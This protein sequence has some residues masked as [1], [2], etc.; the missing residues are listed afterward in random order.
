MCIRDSLYGTLFAIHV[1]DA[2]AALA[3]SARWPAPKKRAG[4]L[5]PL[6]SYTDG[7]QIKP[8]FLVRWQTKAASMLLNAGQLGPVGGQHRSNQARLFGIRN[9]GLQYRVVDNAGIVMTVVVSFQA[10][11][12]E[13]LCNDKDFAL[14][15]LKRLFLGVADSQQQNAGSKFA[16][17]FKVNDEAAFNGWTKQH[18]FRRKFI[19]AIPRGL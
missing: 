15:R 6:K 10:H 7:T 13:V 5:F 1:C 17:V 3:R 16:H 8:V 9:H 19:K 2:R 4:P 11:T 14:S 12:I 18:K